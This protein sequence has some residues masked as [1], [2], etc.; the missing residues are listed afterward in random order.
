M[1]GLVVVNFSLML[2]FFPLAAGKAGAATSRDWPLGG[3]KTR[4]SLHGV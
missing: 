4:E 1:V 2:H 3:A